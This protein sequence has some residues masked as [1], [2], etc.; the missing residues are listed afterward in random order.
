M[1]E[2]SDVLTRQTGIKRGDSVMALVGGGGY[3][4]EV[5]IIVGLCT[6]DY[7]SLQNILWFPI[8]LW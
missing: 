1:E 2:V 7:Y 3:A 8:R 4:G 5:D 6:S